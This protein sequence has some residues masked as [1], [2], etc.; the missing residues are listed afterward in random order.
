MI[1]TAIDTFYLT[2][3]QLLDSPSRKDGVHENAEYTLRIFG[4]TLVQEAGILL[5]LF[6]IKSPHQNGNQGISHATGT[7]KKSILGISA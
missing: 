5:K 2:E 3:E 4:C 1:Y 6:V 7:T